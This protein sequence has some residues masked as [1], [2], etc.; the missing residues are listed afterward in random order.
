MRNQ[1]NWRFVVEEAWRLG[2]PPLRYAPVVTGSFARAAQFTFVP[3]RTHFDLY[4]NGE[5]RYALFDRI[6]AEMY[7][8]AKPTGKSSG[9]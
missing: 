3:G 8:V 4:Q 1:H 5:D 7:S 2:V 6:A 9:K